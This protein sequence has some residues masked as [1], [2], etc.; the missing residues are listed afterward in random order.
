MKKIIFIAGAM[1][2]VCVMTMTGIFAGSPDEANLQKVSSDSENTVT[3]NTGKNYLDI[4]QDGICDNNVNYQCS[5]CGQSNCQGNSN[6]Q[7]N[8]VDENQDGICDNKVS[9]QCSTCGQTNCQGNSNCQQNYVDE[10]QNGICNHRQD[11]V[12]TQDGTG[13][14]LQ[15]HKGR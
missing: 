3:E 13:R 5:T 4:N 9:N 8:Y 15:H 14:Q 12:C 6:C 7:Q 11:K 1:I 10:D 2:I